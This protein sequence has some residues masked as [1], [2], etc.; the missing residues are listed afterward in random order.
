[1]NNWG[2]FC[3]EFGCNIILDF[4][5][6]RLK[7]TNQLVNFLHYESTRVSPRSGKKKINS[8]ASFSAYYND[9]KRYH[10]MKGLEWNPTYKIQIKMKSLRRQYSK[11]GNR[12]LPLLTSMVRRFEKFKLLDIESPDDAL[13]A[14]VMLLSIHGLFRISELLSEPEFWVEEVR[15]VRQVHIRLTDSKTL[16]RNDGIPEVV[17]V[18]EVKG[19]KTW[20]PVRLLLKRHFSMK[21]DL[22]RRVV[23]MRMRNGK[24]LSRSIYSKKLK[25]LL[26]MIGIDSKRY[27]THSGRIGGA[28]MM[29]EAG[30]TDAQIK[31]FGRW[32]SESW[33][34]YCRTLKD[35]FIHLARMI[36]ESDINEKDIVVDTKDLVIDMDLN[37]VD[38][39]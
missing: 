17:V 33:T 4:Q 24:K 36:N 14:M 8:F 27:D 15:G 35:K 11:G 31:R 39:K 20:C 22:R 9:V 37:W 16:W 2:L 38:T 6:A 34:I 25:G 23:S 13:I 12:K 1:M 10:M 18:S 21:K 28:T 32:K 7:A 26:S 19:S 3:E 30:Y 5:T 29:W